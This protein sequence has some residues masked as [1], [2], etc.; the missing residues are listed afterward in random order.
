M[1]KTSSRAVAALIAIAMLAIAV[2]PVSASSVKVEV[3]PSTQTADW[4]SQTELYVNFTYPATSLISNALNNS[5]GSLSLNITSKSNTSVTAVESINGTIASEY[6][7]AYISSLVMYYNASWVANQTKL[8]VV[9]TSSLY[10]A[11]KGIGNGTA[12]SV[13]MSWKD[14]NYTKSINI[15]TTTSGTV[16]INS[17]SGAL[18]Y[19]KILNFFADSQTHLSAYHALDYSAFSKQLSHW[20]RTYDSANGQTAYSYDAGVTVNRSYNISFSSSGTVQ[21]YSLSVYL[22]PSAQI[23]TNG[24]TYAVGNTLYVQPSS[25]P[26]PVAYIAAGVA[27]ILVVSGVAAALLR[28]RSKGN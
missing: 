3:N 8:A 21:N 16:D 19:S 9:I 25:G 18:V 22:D 15:S 23:V 6:R 4:H 20:N 11:V 26:G 27:V 5:S 7:H 12:G 28:R 13:N 24:N 10:M 1:R 17:P 14:F 2:A